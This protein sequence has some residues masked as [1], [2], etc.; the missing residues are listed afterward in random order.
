M[1]T[2]RRQATANLHLHLAWVKHGGG[3]SSVYSFV[4]PLTGCPG[5]SWRSCQGRHALRTG[6]IRLMFQSPSTCCL[7]NLLPLSHSASSMPGAT[8][9]L[10]VTAR[11][12]WV[13]LLSAHGPHCSQATDLA[14][15]LHLPPP[16]P[17]EKAGARHSSWALYYIHVEPSFGCPLTH[18][19][20]NSLKIANCTR[21]FCFYAVPN[22][23]DIPFCWFSPDA[24][25]V[26]SQR[27]RLV[28]FLS[29][30]C[31][32]RQCQ[33]SL[34]SESSLSFHF[35]NDCPQSLWVA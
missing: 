33:G 6:Q 12:T 17:K 5:Q 8:Q 32:L 20:A 18:S 1:G 34:I 25:L 31:L 21:V 27:Q 11:W 28:I 19:S 29:C 35:A 2:A 13:S 22:P 9:R 3:F 7:S 15:S 30:P 10:C 23:E 16:F 26:Q 24:A 14:V 4:L